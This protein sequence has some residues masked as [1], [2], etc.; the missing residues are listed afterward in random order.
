LCLVE[1]YGGAV[2]KPSGRRRS[3]G[4]E[5]DGEVCKKQMMIDYNDVALR[6]F[7]TH[8]GDEAAVVFFALLAEASIGARIEL[9]PERARLGQF[10]EFGAIAGLRRLLPCGNGAVVLDLFKP[11]E[12]GL[13]GEI[14]QLLAAKIIIASL[15]V[16]DAQFAIA[17]REQRTLQRGNVFEK[18]L[19][20]QIFC[21]SRNYS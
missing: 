16:A 11:A 6:G 17:F 3:F 12:D 10:G 20:L 19:F 5:L 2:R 21:A 9:V 1:N 13:V 14:D 8:L 7:A 15:H 18:K 4:F